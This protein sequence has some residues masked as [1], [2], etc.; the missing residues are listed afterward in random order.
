MAASETRVWGDQDELGH[1]PRLE[2]QS[3]G[4]VGRA[5]GHQLS[6]LGG[7]HGNGHCAAPGLSMQ[8][9][10][11]GQL[12]LCEPPACHSVPCPRL[13]SRCGVFTH[14]KAALPSAVPSKRQAQMSW[15]EKL[16]EQSSNVPKGASSAPGRRRGLTGTEVVASSRTPATRPVQELQPRQSP[17][18]GTQRV[19]LIRS[20]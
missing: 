17:G 2:Q 19:D 13:P 4:R 16:Q 3:P 1:C 15:G 10:T 6:N 12:S 7:G 5:L 20:S 14:G 9:H 18:Q 11:V 8:S